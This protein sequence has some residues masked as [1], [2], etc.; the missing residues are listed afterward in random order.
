MPARWQHAL[1][2][3]STR[4]EAAARTTDAARLGHAPSFGISAAGGVQA[5][6]HLVE[7]VPA[8][9]LQEAL[10]PQRVQADGHAAQS[11]LPV[12]QIV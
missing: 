9:Q 8:G 1:R 3:A 10:A 7:G 4:V 12:S 11:G 6:E 2:A 5:G